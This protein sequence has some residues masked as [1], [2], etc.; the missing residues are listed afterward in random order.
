MVPAGRTVWRLT[1]PESRHSR[2]P[3]DP[4][5]HRLL[6]PPIGRRAL[7]ESCAKQSD[8]ERGSDEHGRLAARQ[9]LGVAEQLTDILVLEARGQTLEL[10][11]RPVDVPAIVSCCCSRSSCVVRLTARAIVLMPSVAMSFCVES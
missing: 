7:Q 5:P 6:M 4:L 10:I 11:G 8:G 1:K 3:T 9:T 2:V